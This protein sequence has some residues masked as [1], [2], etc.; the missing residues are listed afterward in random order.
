MADHAGAVPLAEELPP[1]SP[2]EAV[3]RL[4]RLPY[5]LFLDSAA[6][7]PPLGRFSYV[8]ADPFAVLRARGPLVS[9][10]DA[11]GLVSETDDPFTV[12]AR[13]LASFRTAPRPDLPPF[14]GGAA[15]LF[16]YDLRH[17]LER[18]PPAAVDEFRTPDLAVGFYD[19]VIA[20]DHAA[21]RSWLLS[22]GLP[23]AD[24]SARG[25]RDRKSTR[26]N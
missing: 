22:T 17:H 4:D 20:F 10:S 14:Q 6:V 5:L 24:E 18:L 12:L 23:E 19:W 13:R 7:G 9:W 11:A 15:G 1:L 8:C 16:G 21:G 2:W 3:R 25:E 26:L